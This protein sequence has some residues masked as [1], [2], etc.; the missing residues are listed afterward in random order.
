MVWA[1]HFTCENMI[2]TSQSVTTKTLLKL[3]LCPLLLEPAAERGKKWIREQ[4]RFF[5]K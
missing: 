2:T 1:S 5:K 3:P 4:E